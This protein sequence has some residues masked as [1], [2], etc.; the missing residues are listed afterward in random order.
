MKKTIY[1]IL[2]VLMALTVFAGC[3]K[4]P[5]IPI[6]VGKENDGW[7]E[8]ELPS[9]KVISLDVPEKY[10]A[11]L[12]EGDLEI[13]IDAGVECP[14]QGAFPVYILQK[15]SFTQEQAD[16]IIPALI[17][18]AELYDISGTRTKQVIG[19]E[20]EQYSRQL[21]EDNEE[22]SEEA[23]QAYREILESLMQEQAAAPEQETMTPASRT[24]EF[25]ASSDLE[26]DYAKQVQNDRGGYDFLWTEEAKKRRQTTEIR[27]SA[28]T[29]RLRT[30]DICALP[31]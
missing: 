24:F 9:E 19:Q 22:V 13:C 27:K 16:R 6:V 25:K 7:K 21:A 15:G 3:Q 31:Y 5:E 8:K 17:G 28:G 20:I 2:V 4:T 1:I 14:E 30:A 18:D 12:T 11:N 23:K 10:E 26:F 29:V